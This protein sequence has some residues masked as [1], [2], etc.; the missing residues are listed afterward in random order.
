M[1]GFL[2]FFGYSLQVILNDKLYEGESLQSIIADSG[3]SDNQINK[4]IINNGTFQFNGFQASKYTNLDE[5]IINEGCFE[6]TVDDFV[7]QNPQSLSKITILADITFQ[8]QPFLGC[9]NLKVVEFNSISNLSN[10]HIN[11]T[12]IESF[13]LYNQETLNN[14]SITDIE[15]LKTITLPKC[16]LIDSF[17]LNNCHN[18]INISFPSLQKVNKNSMNN[19]RSLLY[20]DLPELQ[21]IYD[22]TFQDCPRIK[23]F[24]ADKVTHC[25]GEHFFIDLVEAS[26]KELFFME[27][28][29]FLYSPDLEKI[30][31][32]P[33]ISIGSKWFDSCTNL[34]YMKLDTSK[35]IFGSFLPNSK[36][37]ETLIMEN[38]KEFFLNESY[39]KLTTL[40]LPKCENIQ[41]QLITE[42]KNL[43]I[44][45][46]N[47]MKFS[48]FINDLSICQIS[49]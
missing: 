37:L 10:N 35:N 38:V 13:T 19:L 27:S 14:N 3:L 36:N 33:L 15:S 22:K 8:Q 46:I 6:G 39:P 43:S 20:V 31:L 18:I 26:F 47:I 1:I 30:Y 29:P 49:G 34:K 11:E 21:R 40:I 42:A 5:F 24:N 28:S 16:K 2:L 45:V 48:Q 9:T 32:G 44:L 12:K 23:I 17:N 7:F 4:I 25:Y 41:E